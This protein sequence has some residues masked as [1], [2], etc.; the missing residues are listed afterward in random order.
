MLPHGDDERLPVPALI[1]N[2]PKT[3]YPLSVFG[4]LEDVRV[5]NSK[6][7]HCK[8]LKSSKLTPSSLG[9]TSQRGSR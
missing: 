3:S 5:L 9:Q 1:M 2:A 7:P 6:H 8:V 4:E